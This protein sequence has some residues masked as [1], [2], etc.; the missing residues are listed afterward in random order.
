MNIQSAVL[1]VVEV[2]LHNMASSL[3]QQRM[4][5]NAAQLML[6]TGNLIQRIATLILAQ[7]SYTSMFE[8]LYNAIGIG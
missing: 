8:H 4:E 5:E 3:S 7:A 2:L 1:L 6:R